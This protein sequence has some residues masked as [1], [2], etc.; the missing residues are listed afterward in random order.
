M[1]MLL[2][3]GLVHALPYPKVHAAKFTYYFKMEDQTEKKME[4]LRLVSC[5]V[6]I[7]C[8]TGL[9]VGTLETLWAQSVYD[10]PKRTL[11]VTYDQGGPLPTCAVPMLQRC[12]MT[13]E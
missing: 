9:K 12:G 7:G 5:E 8:K 1:Q 13:A 3:A 6:C 10:I 4:Q 2:A 11:R